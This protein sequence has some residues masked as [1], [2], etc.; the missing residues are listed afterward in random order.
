MKHFF[1]FSISFIL[2]LITACSHPTADKEAPEVNEIKA[3]KKFDIILPENHDQGFLWKLKGE[4]DKS[5]VDNLGAVWHGNEKGI[6]FRFQALKN[7]V[8]TLHFTQ[9]KTQE[10]TMER[11]SIKSVTYIIK[12]LQ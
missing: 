8:D 7:G 2:F 10:V 11:D 9:F 6:Y 5:V 12:V 4:S 1:I 3:G